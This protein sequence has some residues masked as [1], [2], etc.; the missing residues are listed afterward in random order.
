[1]RFGR[2]S[3]SG[4]RP[5]KG[6]WSVTRGSSATWMSSGRSGPRSWGVAHR[7][8]NTSSAISQGYRFAREISPTSHDGETERVF[9]VFFFIGIHVFQF[10]R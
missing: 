10:L 2:S 6:R 4:G 7:T 1:M 5:G 8:R 3:R 9:K